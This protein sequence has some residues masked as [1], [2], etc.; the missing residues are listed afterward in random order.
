MDVIKKIYTSSIG[1]SVTKKIVT[2]LTGTVFMILMTRYLGPEKRGEYAY[3]LNTVSIIS[4]LFNLGISLVIPNFIRSKKSFSTNDFLSLSFYQFLFNLLL[5]ILA[6]VL[7]LPI[8]Y[9]LISI[10]S[11]TGIYFMQINNIS[12]IIN[13]NKNC[14]SYSISYII[15]AFILVLFYLF[16]ESNLIYVCIA[17]IS[18]EI[19][20]IIYNLMILKFKLLKF[21]VKWF[22]IIRAGFIP[23]ITTAIIALNYRMDVLMLDYLNIDF[24]LIGIFATGLALAEYTWVIPDIFKDLLLSKNTHNDEIDLINVSLRIS[25]SLIVLISIFFLFFGKLILKILFGEE[26]IDA[27]TVTMLMF[28][29]VPFIIYVKLIG[30]LFIVHGKWNLYFKI[31]TIAV[32]INLV[33]CLLL[34]NKIGINGAAIA[35]IISYAFCGIFFMKWYIDNYNVKLYDIILINRQDLIL[36]KN[37]LFK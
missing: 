10:L 1:L 4:T 26:Y 37:K 21:N 19:I 25:F 13:F 30:T 22:D 36:M 18:K 15:S 3:I 35:S 31:L 5:V 17:L 28:L 6:I 34:I 9:I 32:I 12:L 8:N 2:I 24:F 29:G 27:Y 14:I 20:F 11:C 23:M 7:Q 33:F 16:S